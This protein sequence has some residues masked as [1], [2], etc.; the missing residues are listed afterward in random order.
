M[1]SKGFTIKHKANKLAGFTLVEVL[2]SVILVSAI[3][4]SVVPL[5]QKS[6]T[7]NR[8]SKNKT[9]AVNAASEKIENLRRADFATG[10]VTANWTPLTTTLLKNAEIKVTVSPVSPDLK[11]VEVSIRWNEGGGR[12]QT[13]MLPTYIAKNGIY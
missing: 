5:F 10:V 11:K 3:A 1:S 13:I 12:I 8:T 2:V 9:L 7:V 6:I 4:L